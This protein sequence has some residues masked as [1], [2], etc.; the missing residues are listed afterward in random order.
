MSN[1]VFPRKKTKDMFLGIRLFHIEV[2]NESVQ[3]LWPAF[4]FYRKSNPIHITLKDGTK[5]NCQDRYQA[6]AYCLYF[7]LGKRLGVYSQ[8]E[9]FEIIELSKSIEHSMKKVFTEYELKNNAGALTY[10][11]ATLLALYTLIRYMKP[12]I[13]IQTGVASGVSSSTLSVF[14]CSFC[15]I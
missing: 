14:G 6:Y 9:L 8:S 13:I 11:S 5:L 3:G 15:K 1:I 4:K 12:N 2:V 7:Y 10:F